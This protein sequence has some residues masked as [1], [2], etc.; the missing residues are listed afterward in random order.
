MI[1]VLFAMEFGTPFDS[2]C[3]PDVDERGWLQDVARV[4]KRGRRFHW[5]EEAP[6]VP[7]PVQAVRLNRPDS[8]PSIRT[9]P[10]ASPMGICTSE[11]PFRLSGQVC[12][13]GD[14]FRT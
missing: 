1:T 5:D 4:P 13:W 14:T 11:V 6:R 9:A 12:R 2:L 8:V 10:L 7:V 3:A